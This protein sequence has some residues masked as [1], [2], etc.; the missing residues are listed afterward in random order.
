MGWGWTGEGGGGGGGIWRRDGGQTLHVIKEK[1]I[2]KKT[3][4]HKSC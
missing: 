2:N 1:E 4:L 3:H